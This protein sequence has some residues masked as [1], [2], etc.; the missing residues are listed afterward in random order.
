M[1]G[2]QGRNRTAPAFSGQSN[3]SR[4]ATL[5]AKDLAVVDWTPIGL[6]NAASSRLDSGWT[7][8]F[9][10]FFRHYPPQ[11]KSMAQQTALR[12][13]AGLADLAADLTGQLPYQSLCSEQFTRPVVV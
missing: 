3:Y 5:K 10:L 12:T 7:P 6:Q 2:S 9:E 4:Q 8:D 1:G 13:N 11:L